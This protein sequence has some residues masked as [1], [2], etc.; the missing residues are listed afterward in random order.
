MK[1]IGFSV[2]SV[3]LSIAVHGGISDT[4]SASVPP[5]P[6]TPVPAPTDHYAGSAENSMREREAG[7]RIPS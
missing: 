2:L 5:L 4:L 7:G 6:P 1:T 3:L